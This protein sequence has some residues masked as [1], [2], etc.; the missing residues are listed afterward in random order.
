MQPM[1]VINLFLLQF[2]I[3]AVLLAIYLPYRI[4][5]ARRRKRFAGR[6]AVPLDDWHRRYCPDDIAAYAYINRVLQMLGREVGCAPTQIL[7]T[8]RFAVEFGL[9]PLFIVTSDEFE[10]MLLELEEIAFA[11]LKLDPKSVR[12]KGNPSKWE[13]VDDIIKYVR[14][15]VSESHGATPQPASPDQPPSVS[16]ADSSDRLA[17]SN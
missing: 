8:D 14:Y 13:C 1:N 16:R 2:A 6:E 11:E 10:T 4:G 15:L 17:G 12:A 3:L 7:P 5:L 9:S